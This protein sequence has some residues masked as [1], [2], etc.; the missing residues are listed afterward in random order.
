MG[1]ERGDLQGRQPRKD[2][3][4]ALHVGLVA[5]ETCFVLRLV[6]GF[7]ADEPAESPAA[8]RGMRSSRDELLAAV[9]VVGR[10]RERCVAHDVNG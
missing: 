5:S 10:A 9:D 7:A 3:V 6:D 8:G 4:V 1:P 2:Q